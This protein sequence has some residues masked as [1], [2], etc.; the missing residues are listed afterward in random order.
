MEMIDGKRFYTTNVGKKYPSITTIL[1]ST[2]E[3]DKA[4]ILKNWQ[5][6]LGED[7]ANKVKEDAAIRGTALHSLME[8]Y[9]FGED[10]AEEL[11]NSTPLVRKMFKQFVPVLKRVDNIRMLEKP[12]YSS[13]LRIAGRVDMIAEFDGKLSIIDFKT[14]TR[15]KTVDMIGDYLL[16]ECFYSICYAEHFSEKIEQIV[17][18]VGTEQSLKAYVFIDNPLK[19][20]NK[21][22]AR[23]KT[24]YK[25]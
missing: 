17:T 23:I 16:Q 5:E 21:L 7:E 20:L 1:S 18:I 15:V 22:I 14:S 3:L 13:G 10:Y 6:R 24:Y 25:N 2:M 19:H 8:K 4:N 12:L 9:L 11:K